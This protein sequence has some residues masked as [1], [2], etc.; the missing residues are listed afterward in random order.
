MNKYVKKSIA[1]IVAAVIC[2]VFIVALFFGAHSVRNIPEAQGVY[3]YFKY[4]YDENG[5][6]VTEAV[7]SVLGE[8]FTAVRINDL[9]NTGRIT[10]V[11]YVP[12]KFIAPGLLSEEFQIV[13]LTKSFEFA[14]K[15]TLMFIVMNIEPTDENYKEVL[16]ELSEFRIG[17]YLHFGLNLPE[18]YCA[19]NVYNN[20][21]LIA[22]IGEIE[23]YDFINFTTMYD[24][25]TEHF[26]AG[27][28]RISVDLQFYTRLHAMNA[29]NTVTIHY[30]SSST[31]YAGITRSPLIGPE[32][33]L[34]SIKDTS[35]NLLIAFSILSTTVFAVLAALSVLERSK[36]FISALVYVFG[37]TV[38][39]SSRFL[40]GGI[41]SAPLLLAALAL[42]TSHIILAGALLALS[43]NFGKFPAKYIFPA[44][45]ALG[46]LLAF[47][48][49]YTSF[50]A[51][52]GLKIACAVV[53]GVCVAALWAFI[54][55]SVF[56]KNSNYG[57]LQTVCSVIIAV[58]VTASL[59]MPQIYPAQINPFF[60]L[61]SA[62]TFATFISVFIM[63]ME[64]RKSNVYLTANLHNEVERQVEDIR[65]I[66]SE[67]DNLLQFVSHD[68]KKPISSSLA[69][70]DA[71]IEREKD[72]E[73]VKALKIV[74]QNALH[75]VNNLSQ[76]G[77]YAKFNYLAEHSEVV[78]LSQLCFEL[79]RF[80][81][82]DCNANGIV[83]K[84]TA[85]KK[86]LAYVKKQG[87]YNAVSNIIMNA[88][89]HAN[90]STITLSV[91]SERKRAV[92][93][94]ADDGK[95]I[96]GSLDV[97]K[98]YVSENSE[99]GGVGL[100][101]CKSIVESMNGELDYESKNGCT[102]FRFSLP[103]A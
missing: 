57:I 60:W 43:R 25:K 102:I 1:V 19:S 6:P 41:A 76:I 80:H 61:C 27:T 3:T 56:D 64:T 55:I 52:Y 29:I 13:D 100:F 85:Q 95:G 7:N 99:N 68:L 36:K 83:L 39:L 38:M 12:D 86:C 2:A 72:G 101:I 98:A 84:N 15:G 21:S 59:F 89:E 32:T 28:E 54:G 45:A 22:R 49:P 24:K 18:I 73:Q 4:S 16:E 5:K 23:N 82:F 47:V 33:S 103:K 48:T 62:T 69:I 79:C 65:S 17:D 10:K 35:D 71:T 42:A 31:S 92:L 77:G 96:D 53:K 40:I 44:L 75:V 11:N 94:V 66:I 34:K 50:A 88:V 91:K 30:Q 46:A 87:L 90:C 51:A 63:F 14:K 58:A 8:D 37:I 67:R 81:T 93:C 9:K 20:S 70:L 74:R 97:F 78:D 26:S